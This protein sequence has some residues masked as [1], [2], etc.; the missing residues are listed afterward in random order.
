MVSVSMLTKKYS[1]IGQHILDGKTPV[2]GPLSFS[3]PVN[4]R[5]SEPFLCNT[6][7]FFL[8]SEGSRYCLYS[9]RLYFSSIENRIVTGMNC[10]HLLIHFYVHKQLEHHH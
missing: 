6:C 1:H 3:L 2:G 7:V 4:R 10:K 5:S 8:I 9:F